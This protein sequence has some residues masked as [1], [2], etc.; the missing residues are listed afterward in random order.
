MPDQ[1]LQISKESFSFNKF[2]NEVSLEDAVENSRYPPAFSYEVIYNGHRKVQLEKC[3]VSFKL[4][5]TKPA[6]EIP[7]NV[8]TYGMSSCVDSH[9]SIGTYLRIRMCTVSCFY[10]FVPYTCTYVCTVK[11]H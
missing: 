2:G 1:I 7:V 5:P 4:S 9:S 8:D 10:T 3:H 6:V 11:I